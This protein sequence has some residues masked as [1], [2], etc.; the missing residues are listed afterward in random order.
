MTAPCSGGNPGRDRRAYTLVELLV[1]L[2]IVSLLVALLL[3]AAQGAREA[4][5][6]ASCADHLRQMILATHEFESSEGGFPAF[7]WSG[8]S[9]LSPEP[10]NFASP[11]CALLPYLEQR[12]TFN[13]I[14]F[15][16]RMGADLRDLGPSGN[17]TVAGRSIAAFLCPSDPEAA[18]SGSPLAPISYRASFGTGETRLLRP[19]LF[20]VI[21][22]G[23]F[24]GTRVI[25]PTGAFRDGLAN[26]LA[27]A[28]KPVGSG[29]PGPYHAFRDW[30]QTRAFVLTADEWVATCSS[31][32]SIAGGRNDA[33]AT[34]LMRDHVYTGFYTKRPPNDTVPDCGE[35]GSSGPG[36]FTSRSY[37]PGGVNAALCDG[38]VRF[39]TNGTAVAVW[40]ALGTR[41]ASD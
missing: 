35:S 7:G 31:L 26:T 33:G 32:N 15:M 22:D 40:R 16:A 21:E 11:Q 17:Q 5:R 20:E 13:A 38:S 1:S 39:F 9:P 6:R 18:A 12:D 10:P 41:A 23:A 8:L 2:G 24:V 30:I 36:V 29:P 25:L 37:H 28:E 27:F 14:N 3:P 34:W 4:A 19:G